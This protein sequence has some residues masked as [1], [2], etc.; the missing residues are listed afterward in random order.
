[1]LIRLPCV[2]R[3][4]TFQCLFWQCSLQNLTVAAGWFGIVLSILLLLGSVASLLNWLTLYPQGN[5][6][7]LVAI[8]GFASLLVH[9]F[10]V[11]GA[12]NENPLLMLPYLLFTL[13]AFAVVA[14]FMVYVLMR[15]YIV[16]DPV[17][18]M[19]LTA[20]AAISA[21]VTYNV[22]TGIY[23]HY[24]ELEDRLKAPS[25]FQLRNLGFEK[26]SESD[27]SDSHLPL[28]KECSFNMTAASSPV[29]L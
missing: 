10:L 7:L 16:D 29:S 28:S 25:E 26:E 24:R 9:C 20:A 1:M 17:I 21:A 22:W 15:S 3:K 18:S 4:S 14:G 11:I 2:P 5:S 8:F 23:S 13:A 19:S 27:M 12:R 6:P